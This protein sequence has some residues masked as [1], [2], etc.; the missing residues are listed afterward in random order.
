MIV[1]CRMLRIVYESRYAN[2][3]ARLRFLLMCIVAS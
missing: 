3:A 1:I 2:T